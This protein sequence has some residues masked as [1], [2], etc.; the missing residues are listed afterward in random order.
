MRLILKTGKKVIPLFIL[1]VFAGFCLLVFFNT[2]QITERAKTAL[3]QVLKKY[4]GE[5]I[6][7]GGMT[8]F[9]LN[10]V[11]LHQVKVI[12]AE[13]TIFQA[14]RI[15]VSFYLHNLFKGV[16]GILE[17]I[18]EIQIIRPEVHLI[19][20]EDGF[21][22]EKYIGQGEGNRDSFPAFSTWIRLIDGKL[23]YND[24][25][26]SESLNQLNGRIKIKETKV[27]ID[28]D[29]QIEGLKQSLI[30][31]KGSVSPELKFELSFT[32]LPFAVFERYGVT[33]SGVEKLKGKGTGSVQVKRIED[34][35]LSYSG[36]ITIVDGGMILSKIPIEITQ[37]QGQINFN[38][39]QILIQKLNGETAAGSFAVRGQISNLA[40]P[41]VSLNITTDRFQLAKLSSLIPILKGKDLTGLAKGNI[42]VLGNLKDPLIKVNLTVP[43]IG[44]QNLK[45]SNFHTSWWYQNSFLTLQDLVFNFDGGSFKGYSGY[46][47]FKNQEEFFYSVNVET[48]NFNL[49]KFLS[50]LE[51]G[52]KEIPEGLLT[53]NFYVFGE[54]FNP[55][56]LSTIGY[57]DF[58]NGR[59]QG[60]NF[61]RLKANFWFTAGELGLSKVELN[62]PYLVTTLTGNIDIDGEIDL[63][64][65][66][67][68]ID[69]IWLG[70]RLD[71][72]ARGKGIIQGEV[73]GSITDPYFIGEINLSEGQLWN[74]E[75][76]QLKGRIKVDKSELTL[77]DTAIIKGESDFHLTGR[78]DFISEN[79]DLRA[80][81]LKS[82]I[83]MLRETLAFMDIP[84]DF[85]G[86]ITGKVT[87]VGPWSGI[88]VAGDLVATQGV[89][90]NQPYDRAVLSFSWKEN[91][92]LFN[93]F[94][95][96]Y[97][98]T[99]LQASGVIEDYERLEIEM[100]GQ[101][102]DLT[103]IQQIRDHFPSLTG[104]ANFRGRLTGKT[105]S[106]SFWGTISSD[107]IQYKGVPIEQLSALLQYEEGL[108][109]IRPM[110]VING[111]NEY[112]LI[113]KISFDQMVLDMQIR[114][115]HARIS[116][117]LRFTDLSIKDLDYTM[118]GKIWIRGNLP[119]PEVKLDVI[120]DDGKEGSLALKGI[121]DF[122]QG[123]SLQLKG[124]KF[125]L[126]PFKLY[127]AGN[128]FDYTLDGEIL[129]LGKLFEPTAR[130]NVILNDAHAGTLTV[131]GI[132][133][134]NEIDLD[135]KGNKFDLTPLKAY[136]PI[137]K[138]T[139]EKADLLDSDKIKI[140]NVNANLNLEFSNSH[141]DN[142][143]FEYLAG[144][145]K[146]IDGSTVV[147]NQEL[148]LPDGNDIKV[149]G[150]VPL[151]DSDGLLN[152][153]IDMIQ[154]NLEVL[155]LLVP[156]VEDA[157]GE[158]EAYFKISG[159]MAKPLLEGEIDISSGFIKIYGLDLIEDIKGKIILTQGKAHIK[160]LEG[161]IGKGHL[162]LKGWVTLNGFIPDEVNFDLKTKDYHF[163]YGSIDALGDANL[164]VK[165]PFLTPEVRGSILVHDA[166]IGV[167]PFEW[168]QSDGAMLINP[169]FYL[170][171]YPGDNVRVTGTSPVNLNVTIIKSNKDKL[172]VDTTGKE[173]ILSGDLHARSGTFNIYNSNFRI[174][175]A[176]ASF[177]K[178]NKYIPILHVQAQTNIRNYLIFLDL[179]GLPTDNNL[180]MKLYSEPELTEHEI[181][182]LL[183]NQGGLG[184]FLAGNGD[185]T[186][187]ISEEIWRYINQ[188]LRNEFLNRLEESIEKALSLDA[189][190]LDPVLLGDARINIQIG[191]YLDD[192]LYVV[193]S[194][195]FSQNPE[196]SIGFEYQIHPNIGIE[197]TYKGAGNYQF[198][199]KVDFPF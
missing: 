123:M 6:Q 100:E 61:N 129:V 198:G 155:P 167:V 156:G 95:I 122:G 45:F 86:D 46:I 175:W 3:I 41:V 26:I 54:G 92:I 172:V 152:L 59:Y 104:R 150:T 179:D 126:S 88:Q 118:D 109:M 27:E 102:F 67:S 13:Q 139:T 168:P 74:Q 75:F 105:T 115:K 55:D 82:S 128:D 186:D 78:I 1:L 14:E 2:D 97:K 196:Q 35:A 181:T 177:V 19:K 125:D 193:Y 120:L 161:R 184:E 22:F 99:V 17:G 80:E 18:K 195:T 84:F 158:G 108:L 176:T 96:S 39:K 21:N 43:E 49:Y 146:I 112:T 34:K 28:V 87:L 185:V 173:L 192:D 70:E 60:I 157:G 162:N 90:L 117:L 53:G 38:D 57:V 178:F 85:T 143:L 160:K 72:P 191:K 40:D 182:M 94:E 116:E 68:F 50:A 71:F 15:V 77:F 37:V 149:R 164:K 89:V 140:G 63:T 131:K 47:N 121:Y 142:Y 44:Y 62:T 190:Y 183:A 130:L 133:N 166:E 98:N 153:K 170:E 23:Y 56:H 76:D 199:L 9:P 11:T 144:T 48:V 148:I 169:I 132:F 119:A 180:K 124:N 110:K 24:G 91:D 33:I 20:G 134:L 25:R 103:D 69:L 16:D 159:T 145:I 8:L 107:S 10:R 52:L 79:L 7:I 4:L 51:P 154:G 83:T 29:F 171:L 197:G 137:G 165:G 163:V 127:L 12:T 101:G 194:R 65:E 32:D 174:N 187:V 66:P 58:R 138:N 81:I 36:R 113:G 30:E 151:F 73:R 42:E 5:D 147:L 106:P 188:G 111:K 114:T 64:I 93:N 31:L 141:L 136:L 189:F 135:L